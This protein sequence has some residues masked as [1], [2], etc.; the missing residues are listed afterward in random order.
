LCGVARFVEAGEN[1]CSRIDFQTGTIFEVKLRVNAFQ[2]RMVFARDRG[3]HGDCGAKY[4]NPHDTPAADAAE[5]LL[6]ARLDRPAATWISNDVGERRESNQPS[7]N[8]MSKAGPFDAYRGR[9]KSRLDFINAMVVWDFDAIEPRK[10]D[11]LH[12]RA[13]DWPIIGGQLPGSS[14]RAGAAPAISR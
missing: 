5:F 12:P 3:S 4:S 10:P 8:G 11:P 1:N 9:N 14:H 2:S 7:L 6:H 13:I